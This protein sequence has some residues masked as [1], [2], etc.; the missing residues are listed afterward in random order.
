MSA[1]RPKRLR[2]AIYTRKS[3][4]EGLE[5]AFNSLD[6]QRESCEAYIK[7]RAG[8]GWHL[9][10]TRYDDGGVSGGTMDRPALQQRLADIKARKVDTCCFR[11]APPG[12]RTFR[13][14][15]CSSRTAAMMTRSTA[16]CSS[17][18]GS[19]DR[20]RPGRAIGGFDLAG[21]G[22]N[23]WWHRPM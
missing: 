1:D 8:E 13:P 10:R 18:A 6:A 20:G 17:W 4:E 2:C 12:C 15:S 22:L 19:R 16:S 11:N 3:S 23:R 21:V 7:S 14:R 9:I 5:Q